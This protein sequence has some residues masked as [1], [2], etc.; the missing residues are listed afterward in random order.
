MGCTT[1]VH[2]ITWGTGSALDRRISLNMGRVSGK[3]YRLQRSRNMDN[4][5]SYMVSDDRL[6]YLHVDNRKF[7]SMQDME[8]AIGEWMYERSKK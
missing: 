3:E 7:L 8:Q 2:S 1:K 6:T 5:W 4:S